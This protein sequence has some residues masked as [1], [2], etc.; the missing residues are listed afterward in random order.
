MNRQFWSGRRVF[1]TGHTGFK[2]SWLAQWLK[3]SGASV[4]GFSIDVPT[5]PSL[6]ESAAIGDGMRSIEGDVRDLRALCDAMDQSR[7]EIVLHLAAQALV[8]PSYEDPVATYATN[9]MGTANVL[10]A[11]RRSAGIRV[12]VIVTSDKCYENRESVSPYR[13]NDPM[14]GHDPYSSSK[15][16]AEL[17]TAAFRRSFFAH[18]DAPRVISVRAGNVIGGGDWARDRLVPDLVRAFAASQAAVIRNPAAIRPWQFVLDPLNGYLCAAEAVYEHADLPQAWNF[19][20]DVND[21]HPVKW[22]ADRIV[23]CWGRG[24]SWVEDQTVQPHEASTL[25]LDS[26]RARSLLR[27]KPVLDAES[28]I[29]WAVRWYHA[30]IEDPSRATIVTEQQIR[31]YEKA[32][33]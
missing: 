19:G 7:P 4:T 20:P 3:L 18:H 15:G 25:K 10:E 33:S 29:D 1:L 21:T 26:S 22:V 12:V 24:A 32:R 5:R 13:E 8:R 14:G 17:V 6:Y 30:W 28:A 31:E 27:W 23:S 11:V 9:V 2:G 16:C